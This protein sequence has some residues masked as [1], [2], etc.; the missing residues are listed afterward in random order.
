MKLLWHWGKA[1]LH[2]IDC[3]RIF[4]TSEIFHV[5]FIPKDEHE[6]KK[7]QIISKN[8]KT[9]LCYLHGRSMMPTGTNRNT[10]SS[11]SECTENARAC[12]WCRD[13][14]I[15][16]LR[17]STCQDWNT[18]KHHWPTLTVWKKIITISLSR[19]LAALHSIMIMAPSSILLWDTIM[20]ITIYT[21][22]L[23]HQSPVG[24][25]EHY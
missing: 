8:A 3:R 16:H 25:Q 10:C 12:I 11:Q 7:L 22:G 17:V 14:L 23:K 9:L 24:S 13:M 4:K 5:I 20:L 19:Q 18:M 1:V 15:T 6:K 2:F 21:P